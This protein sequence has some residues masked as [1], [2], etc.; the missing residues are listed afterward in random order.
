[1]SKYEEK[2]DGCESICPYCEDS[3]QVEAE[4]YNED[5]REEQCG[6]CGNKYWLS[7]VFTVDHNTRPDCE[8]NGAK[9]EYELVKLKNGKQA[10]FCTVC[11]DCKSYT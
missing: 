9:H 2:I 10:Y 1:M 6:S 7:E 3:F 8:L 5:E 11:D 4:D